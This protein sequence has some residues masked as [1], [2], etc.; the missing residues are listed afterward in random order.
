MF[1]IRFLCV[2]SKVKHPFKILLALELISVT[3]VMLIRVSIFEYG[4]TLITFFCVM[5]IEGAF[6]LTLFVKISL[7]Q[8]FRVREA[9]NIL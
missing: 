5:V 8:S 7:T 3:L 6:G 1:A 4:L 2:V 9:T